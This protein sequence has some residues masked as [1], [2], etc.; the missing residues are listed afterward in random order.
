MSWYC[1][2]SNRSKWWWC[3]A[4]FVEKYIF[5][6]YHACFLTYKNIFILFY[7]ILRNTKTDL[8]LYLFFRIAP[9][10]IMAMENGTYGLSADIW[11]LGITLIGSLRLVWIW[12]AAVLRVAAIHVMVLTLRILISF[13]SFM[14]DLLQYCTI[15]YHAILHRTGWDEAAVV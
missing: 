12:N 2:F 8:T 15:P 4:V 14:V 13:W 3:V 7:V 11:S 5:I 6:T 1:H 10:V 9:E